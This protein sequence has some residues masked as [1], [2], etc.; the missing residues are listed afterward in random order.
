MLLFSVCIYCNLRT[1]FTLRYNLFGV[2][3]LKLLVFLNFGDYH[4]FLQSF[5]CLCVHIIF[6][7]FIFL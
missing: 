5:T 1:L 3:Q 2:Q 4:F 6:Y 7:V